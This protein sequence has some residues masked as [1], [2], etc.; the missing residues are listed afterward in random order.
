VGALLRREGLYSS[1]RTHWRREVEASEQA[2]LAPERRGPKPDLARA[3]SRRNEALDRE[4]ARLRH[5]LERVEQNIEAQKN[6]A[7]CRYVVGWMI[8][9]RESAELAHEL[10]A[11]T[12]D[13]EG[14][15]RGQLILHADRRTSMR[16]KPVAL[17]LAD[18]GVTKSHSRPHVSNDN[19]YSEAKQLN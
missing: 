15:G 18:L 7:N 16:S 11:A 5:K 6:S 12:C 13:K 2:A 3:E 9:P 8:A 4:V 1:H 17:L 14:I 10:I 19:P